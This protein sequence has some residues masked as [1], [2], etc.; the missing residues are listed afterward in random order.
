MIISV[1]GNLDTLKLMNHVT[2]SGFS[3][4]SILNCPRG[5]HVE[6]DFTG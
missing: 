5:L 3:G 6:V 4:S 2:Y 1:E